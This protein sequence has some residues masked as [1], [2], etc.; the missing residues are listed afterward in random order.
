MGLTLFHNVP[1]GEHVIG[2]AEVSRQCKDPVS[3][4]R[5]P[6]C[7]SSRKTICA[8]V[9]NR[10]QFV[11]STAHDAHPSPSSRILVCNS[12]ANA[13]GC[14]DDQDTFLDARQGSWAS[15]LEAPCPP[16]DQECS[17]G[18]EKGIAGRRAPYGAQPCG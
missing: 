14:A 3:F 12:A 1:H 13:T 4:V 15:G 8:F 6:R 11:P 7:G 9:R 17:E 18:D 16:S 5:R 10:I 2:F